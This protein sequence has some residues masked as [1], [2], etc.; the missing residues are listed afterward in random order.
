MAVKHHSDSYLGKVAKLAP[1]LGPG[2]HHVHVY[3]DTDCAIWRGGSC[4]CRPDVRAERKPR[5]G[6]GK[7]RG[8]RRR[9]ECR[10]S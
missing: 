4:D 3:H 5:G 2:V 9:V 6:R 1:R 7:G 10:F 8:S